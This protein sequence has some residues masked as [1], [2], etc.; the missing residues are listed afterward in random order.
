MCACVRA[1]VRACVCARARVCV[2]VCVC[3]CLNPFVCFDHTIHL[4]LLTFKHCRLIPISHAGCQWCS[5]STAELPASAV[6]TARVIGC[7]R[8]PTS[9]DKTAVR[10]QSG[11][12]R[13][14]LSWWCADM[15]TFNDDPRRVRTRRSG[16]A[17]NSAW[18]QK[19]LKSHSTFYWVPLD[20]CHDSDTCDGGTTRKY[21]QSKFFLFVFVKKTTNKKTT[22]RTFE[23]CA[24]L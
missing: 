23:V 7:C 1:C 6:M 13:S 21:P 18:S 20:T 10:A 14:S 11:L 22:P 17:R 15:R 2:W 24:C 16:Y 9:A 12:R 3:V 4:Y 8:L 5:S 19:R